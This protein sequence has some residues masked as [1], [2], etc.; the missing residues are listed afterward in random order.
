MLLKTMPHIAWP[1]G[2]DLP[3]GPANAGLDG[4]CG[5]GCLCMTGLAAEAVFPERGRWIWRA[6]LPARHSSPNS[7]RHMSIQTAGSMTP[8]WLF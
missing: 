7:P 2:F 5:W 8:A 3:I 6:I 1:M 4:C